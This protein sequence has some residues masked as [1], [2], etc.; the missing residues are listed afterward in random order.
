MNLAFR[1]EFVRLGEEERQLMIELT[2]WA[3]G[4]AAD[5]AKEFYDWQFQFSR[6][7]D[8]FTTISAAK[9]STV[10]DLRTM[11]EGAQ[12][13]YFAGC[14]EGAQN[15]WDTEYFEYRLLVGATHDRINLPF[16]WYIGSYTEFLRV[17]AAKLEEKNPDD[18]KW[19]AY[20]LQTL[21]KVF[22][23]DLQAIADSFV[24]STL[25]S[26]GMSVEIIETTPQ[27]DRTEHIDQIKA[28]ITRVLSQVESLAEGELDSDQ[29]A[30]SD[31]DSILQHELARRVS[32]TQT[33]LLSLVSEINGLAASAKA[34]D[35]T[36]RI[37][38]R[39]Q[40][41]YQ[42]L[43]GGINDM[44]EAILDPINES[45]AVLEKLAQGDLSVRVT[46]Q[47]QGDHAKLADSINEATANISQTIVQ[48]GENASLLAAAAEEMSSASN[49]MG[50]NAEETA[51]QANVVSAAAEEVDKNI[52][53]VAT[54][55]EE[56]ASSIREVANNANEA[57][58]VAAAAVAAAER[59]TVT[60]AELGTSSIEIGNVIKVIT[61]IAQQTNLL[62]LNATI[63]AARAGEAGKGFAVVANEVKEL[64][65]QTAGATEDISQKVQS[66][67][68]DTQGAVSAIEEIRGIIAE[69]NSYQETIAAAVEEQS[70]TTDEIA[71][72]VNE[73][74][75]GSAEIAQNITGVASAA[76]S[77][78]EGANESKKTSVSLADMASELQT[79]VTKFTI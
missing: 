70:A 76:A 11:L 49:Q 32:S 46:G 4:V 21:N 36:A 48:I 30:D 60:V 57:A 23:Y 7:V 26:L 64:A 12:A 22:N 40:G 55:A 72:N 16:K 69:I 18:P 78:T 54:G 14:F 2:P 5:V 31:E 9:G 41:G 20:A 68:D 61:S 79:I 56:M 10:A 28:D 52:Q 6:T 42:D 15:N 19:V 63:E 39:F 1:R 29:F 38:A 74:A 66:I 50:A 73:A 45:A 58:R 71:R 43:V 27:S 35:L 51:S 37:E 24:L 77:T 8:Y 13:G 33:V 59:T 65:K 17:A 34:G 47:Y 44:V 62:A 53:T 3:K 75:R 67:Q 25:G